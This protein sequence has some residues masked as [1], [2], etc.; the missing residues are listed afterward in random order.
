LSYAFGFQFKLDDNNEP[1]LL[2]CNPRIQGTM[3][4]AALA[5]ANVIYSSLKL[6]LDE[7]I[8]KLDVNWDAE[9]IRYW[10]G[11]SVVNDKIVG[12]L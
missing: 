8:P 12:K 3:V 1:K 9:F 10:G 6:L 5:G 7:D 2:E 11:I 4:M